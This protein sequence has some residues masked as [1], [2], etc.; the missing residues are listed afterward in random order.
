MRT[1]TSQQIAYFFKDASGI[2]GMHEEKKFF[3]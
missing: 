2:K 3:A 1:D